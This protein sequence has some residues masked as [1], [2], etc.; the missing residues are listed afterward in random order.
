[1]ARVQVLFAR[2]TSTP[3][4]RFSF[5]EVWYEYHLRSVQPSLSATGVTT[6][7]GHFASGLYAPHAAATAAL[8]SF[9]LAA[10]TSINAMNDPPSGASR[11]VAGP[12]TSRDQPAGATNVLPATVVLGESTATRSAAVVLAQARM[13]SNPARRENEILSIRVGSKIRML[14]SY[15]AA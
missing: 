6:L 9:A 10:G 8:S 15:P 14:I 12:R 5:G 3:T 13:A 4:S 1:M 7:S 11:I 2:R